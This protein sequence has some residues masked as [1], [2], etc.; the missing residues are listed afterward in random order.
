MHDDVMQEQSR[1]IHKSATDQA[2]DQA[3][4]P[5]VIKK[6]Q[7]IASARTV[8][9]CRCSASEAGGVPCLGSA[10]GVIE[11]KHHGLADVGALDSE[12]A[13]QVLEPAQLAALS[14]GVAQR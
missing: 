5:C 6:P 12:R 1:A 7:P 9:V 13:Q 14:A 11:R 4:L 8:T 2:T 3:R 10:V